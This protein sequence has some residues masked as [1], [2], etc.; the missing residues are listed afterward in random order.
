MKHRFVEHP[1]KKH[2]VR[3]YRFEGRPFVKACCFT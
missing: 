3:K 2:R 1:I